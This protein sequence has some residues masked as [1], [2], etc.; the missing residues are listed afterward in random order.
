MA[1]PKV[2]G[3]VPN[4]LFLSHLN[5]YPA[6]SDSVAYLKST[7]YGS[8]SLQY[9][10]QAQAT[11][12]DPLLPY[13]SKPYAYVAPYVHRADALA[14][15]GLD[16]IDARFPIVLEDT[17][18]LKSTARSY[19]AFPAKKYDEAYQHVH[20]TWG[21]EYKKCGGDGY[22]AGGKAALS[23]SLIVT[24]EVLGFVSSWLAQKEQSDKV[25]PQKT[26]Q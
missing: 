21:S 9:A 22:V 12:I 7:H 24:S 10:T 15:R 6:V 17:E 3:E 5:K 14:S 25:V 26:K 4:S 2:N 18:T 20:N 13:A 8:T 19:I 11:L 23:T 1:S 16:H